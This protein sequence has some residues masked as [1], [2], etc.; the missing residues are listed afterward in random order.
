[1]EN[2]IYAVNLNVADKQGICFKMQEMAT[3][4]TLIFKNI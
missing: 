3:L 4:E 1:M 2:Y